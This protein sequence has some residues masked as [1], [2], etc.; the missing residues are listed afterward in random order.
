MARADAKWIALD[1]LDDRGKEGVR[2][3]AKAREPSVST[4][5][6]PELVSHAGTELFHAEE[7]GERSANDHHAPPVEDPTDL[8]H[9]E[10]RQPVEIDFRGRRGPRPVRELL[11]QS[12]QP[13]RFGSLESPPWW[14]EFRS[15]SREGALH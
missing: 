2:L 10:V 9:R 11:D 1:V 15:S 7:V 12:E 8:R 6:M 13:W 4:G 14:D 5:E 3:S